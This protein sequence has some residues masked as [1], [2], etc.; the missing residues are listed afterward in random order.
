MSVVLAQPTGLVANGLRLRKFLWNHKPALVGALIL[1]FFIIIAFLGPLFAPYSATVASGAVYAAPSSHHWLG[2]DDIGIDMVSL[3]L[4]GG[5]TSLIVGAAAA[6]VA[7]VIGGLFGV[8]SGYFGGIV[9]IVLMRITD[10]FLVI[11]DLVLMIVVAAV[12]GPSL[13]HTIL[14]IGLLLWTST[15][16]V[17][18]AQVKSLRERTYV[19][20]ARSVGA[21]HLSIMVRHIVPQIGPLLVANTVITIAVA[22]FDESAL[23]FLGLENPATVSW[24]TI[25]EHANDRTAA[26]NGAW[27]AVV[28]AG[29]CIAAVVVGC[30]LLGSAIEDALNPRL[31]VSHL[32]VRGWRLRAS[33]GSLAALGQAGARASAARSGRRASVS[34]PTAAPP[35]TATAPPP[36]D[37]GSEPS[38]EGES[39]S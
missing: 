2:T 33:V 14:V 4:Y 34:A 28:P 16:R 11:P 21:S 30:Y 38:P 17:L 25:L 5:R 29:A 18:R 10:Y 24:G 12:W 22:I 1:G 13:T 37:P 19:R 7:M 26:S 6:G 9:D 31:A 27:W 15:A 35:P 8:L 36:V 23:A 3:V 20:R 39:Q 32:A